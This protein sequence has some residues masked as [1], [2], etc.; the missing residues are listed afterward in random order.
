MAH[1]RKIRVKQ[2][3]PQEGWLSS[4]ST[5]KQDL[6]CILLLYA[7]TLVLFSK[8][9]FSNNAF[10]SGGD[11]AAAMSYQ[12]VGQTLEQKEGVD[13]IW[14]P[15]FFSGMPTFGNV[16]YIPHHTSYVQDAVQKVLNLLYLNGHETWLVVFYFLSGVL[17]FLLMRGLGFAP[18]LAFF[19]AAAYMLSPY[20]IGLS[21]EGHGSKLMAL[22]YLPL[23]FLCT[24]LVYQRRDFL[25]VGL[26]SAA[27]GTLMLTN[28]VQI[29]YYVLMVV[30]LY[31]LYTIATS[32]KRDRG[33]VVKATLLLLVALAI[34]ACISAYI[35]LSVYEYAQYSIRGGG[36]MGAPGGLTWDYATNWSWSPWELI[37]LLIPGFFGFQMPAYWGP[38]DPWQNSTVYVGLL[39]VLLAAVAIVYR[40]NAQTWFFFILTVVIFLISFG[41]N[42]PL[43]YEFFFKAFP[44]FNKFRAPAMILHL[45]AFTLPILALYGIQFLLEQR[46]STR[47]SKE[48]GTWRKPL[49]VALA[50]VGGL[51]V[52]SALLKTTLY[53]TLSGSMF[54]KAGEEGQF[55]QQ[56]GAQASRA[57][58][59][60]KEM[61]FEIFW[62]DLVKFL[63]LALAS[64]GVLYAFLA[65]KLR[66]HWFILSLSALLVI[67]L[68]IVDTKLIDPKPRSDLE[69]N[70]QAS[71]TITFLKQQPDL[72]RVLPLPFDEHFMDNTYAYHEIA[73]VGGYSPAK[74]KIYQTMLDSCLLRGTDPAFPLNMNIINML[75]VR[76]LIAPGRL[77]EDRFEQ[78]FLDPTKRLIT[79]R[80][81]HVLPRAF[82]V[83]SAIVAGS[84]GDVFANLNSSSFNPSHAAVLEKSP[85]QEILP[86]DS[87]SMVRVV[88][89]ASRAITLEVHASAPGLL[90]LSEIYY[91]AGWKAFVD[92]S[93]TEIY[94]TNSVLRSVI[95]PAG[96]HRVNFSFEP[97]VYSLGYGITNGAWIATLLLILAGV[98]QIPSVRA[99][100][101]LR[102]G[103]RA[104]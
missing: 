32:F 38:I 87:T 68:Y 98:W 50:V 20:A 84:E 14:I 40:R 70:F 73:S 101:H 44:F 62:T 64:G 31:S 46:D 13:V 79:Y 2:E 21:G 61:R 81:P 56:Y 10:S 78:V 82:L 41:R 75:G 47:G 26:L 34:G 99:K 83:D 29:V 85:A 19:A 89:Y 30:G 60:F 76:Y 54:L 102:R 18:F 91:P 100:I 3:Q 66:P 65:R 48:P 51:L 35:Y 37:T 63:A 80:N 72:F 11:T 42:F 4:L 36:T 25:S 96:T 103:K 57:I 93:E 7:I 22:S 45:I 49:L 97:S 8:V 52:L 71:A 90:V 6:L 104:G 86:Q 77:P 16:A 55:R 15:Y 23:V 88:E 67:D 95:V 28:H 58:A 24:H 27:I 53:E 69:R 94:R 9:I 1:T 39:P 17:M 92:G 74:L 43:V 59:Q 12:H 33:T 5:G